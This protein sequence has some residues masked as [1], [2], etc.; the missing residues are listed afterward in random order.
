VARLYRFAP[1]TICTRR[2][3]VR[4]SASDTA[5]QASIEAIEQ[6]DLE[7]RVSTLGFVHKSEKRKIFGNHRLWYE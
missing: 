3:R 2:G 1:G 7:P 5:A 4:M 6:E